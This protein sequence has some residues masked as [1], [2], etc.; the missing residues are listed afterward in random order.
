M[1]VSI[2]SILLK[3]LNKDYL[4]K[5]NLE[6]RMVNNIKIKQE[7]SEVVIYN[8]DREI[9]RYKLAEKITDVMALVCLS[10]NYYAVYCESF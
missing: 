8:D 9:G 2:T 3:M 4:N 10:D 5:E 7:P 1:V 6:I